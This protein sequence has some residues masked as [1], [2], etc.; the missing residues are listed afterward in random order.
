MV[1][2]KTITIE[3]DHKDLLSGANTPVVGDKMR[4]EDRDYSVVKVTCH[5]TTSLVVTFELE[6]HLL[7]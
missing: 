6:L 5:P 3:L 7:G 1:K 2:T 4:I